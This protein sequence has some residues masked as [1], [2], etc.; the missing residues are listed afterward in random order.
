MTSPE[1]SLRLVKL[2]HTIIWAIFA[3]SILAIPVLGWLGH[4]RQAGALI[5]LIFVEVLVLMANGGHCPLTG[6][7]ARYTT[8][9]RDNFDV[10]LPE[11]LARY[12][13][14]IFGSIFIFGVAV[15]FARWTAS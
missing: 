13:K 2:G 1:N 9:R 6:V 7:A 5:V 10:Y 4:D 12:N 11:W 8:D 14:L 3:G 15:T